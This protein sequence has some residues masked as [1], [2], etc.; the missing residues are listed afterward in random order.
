MNDSFSKD[1]LMARIADA[2]PA[3][4]FDAEALSITL[5]DDAVA[6]AETSP[7]AKRRTHL[8]TKFADAYH[9]RPRFVLGSSLTVV[10]S[11]AVISLSSAQL[12]GVITGSTTF[13]SQSSQ[14]GSDGNITEGTGANSAGELPRNAR[15][16]VTARLKSSPL[17]LTGK[18]AGVHRSSD[19][20]P[21]GFKMTAS[22]ELQ[23]LATSWVSD[24]RHYFSWN[25][26]DLQTVLPELQ[27]VLGING[28]WVNFNDN[29]TYDSSGVPV[30]SSL[31]Y[32]SWQFLARFENAKST[33]T[34][35]VTRDNPEAIA[36]LLSQVAEI[37]GNQVIPEDLRNPLVDGGA[38]ALGRLSAIVDGKQV[39]DIAKLDI[40]IGFNDDGT[41]STV[42]GT[43]GT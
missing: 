40:E 4:A 28:E 12:Y 6:R 42:G 13:V 14:F 19:R 7:A 38:F 9:A 35:S 8:A 26:P 5:F 10:A 36:N 30:L 18:I 3:K 1:E 34:T 16:T 11:L 43:L 31:S 41:I 37:T 21:D 23:D 33:L 17:I 15:P 25:K 32:S 2:D 39:G 22:N 20:I 24:N 29:P 27:K